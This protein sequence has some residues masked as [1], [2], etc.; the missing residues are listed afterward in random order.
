MD[1]LAMAEGFTPFAARSRIVVLRSDGSRV[2]R[3]PFDYDKVA[4]GGSGQANFYVR[5]AD[6]VVVP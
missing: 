4:S 2:Q 1:V 3:L 6:I 5:P